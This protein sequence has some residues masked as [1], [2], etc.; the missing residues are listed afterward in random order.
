MEEIVNGIEVFREAF[1]PFSDSFIVI[2]GSACRAVIP[3]GDIRPRKTTDI[4]MVLVPQ[5]L[6]AGFIGSSATQGNCYAPRSVVCPFSPGLQGK[7]Y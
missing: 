4:D 5:E 7:S 2:G 3:E 1:A 6:S